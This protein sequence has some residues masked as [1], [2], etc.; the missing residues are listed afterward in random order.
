MGSFA[1]VD[2]RK[3]PTGNGTTAPLTDTDQKIKAGEKKKTH[4]NSL[5]VVKSIVQG[6][7][8]TQAQ[9]L[10]EIGPPVKPK[11]PVDKEAQPNMKFLRKT[12]DIAR[13]SIDYAK[14]LIKP[15][16]NLLT[17]EEEAKSSEIDRQIRVE[18]YRDTEAKK[19]AK[20]D[21]ADS[22]RQPPR[23]SRRLKQP[24]NESEAMAWIHDSLDRTP[25]RP[26]ASQQSFRRTTSNGS[27][28][29]PKSSRRLERKATPKNELEAAQLLR[30][31]MQAPPS[32][33]TRSTAS[34]TAVRAQYG[35][36]HTA[37]TVGRSLDS[38]R[39]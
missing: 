38:V 29:P 25:R 8:G 1:S 31:L 11:K 3:E 36:G 9:S 23:S 34:S 4:R 20:F 6:W 5:L 13:R 7:G 37:T 17:V 2:D 33:R 10:R 21:G 32:A 22:F 28:A 30:D 39:R 27:D 12:R 14:R 19:S 18:Q 26:V 15:D 35:A 24:A 16:M